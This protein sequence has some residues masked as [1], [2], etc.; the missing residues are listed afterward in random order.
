M[1]GILVIEV[2]AEA[3]VEVAYAALQQS[4]TN[5]IIPGIRYELAIPWQS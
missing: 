2:E 4:V 1:F 3:G 5:D